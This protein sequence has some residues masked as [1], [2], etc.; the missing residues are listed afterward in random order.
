MNSRPV[1]TSNV[2]E[3]LARLT[4]TSEEAPEEG[5]QRLPDET[6]LH[7]LTSLTVPETL[8]ARLVCRRWDRLMEDRSLWHFFL[9]RDF[10]PSET[11]NPKELYQENYRTNPNLTRGIYSTRTVPISKNTVCRLA[12][13]KDEK[14]IIPNFDGDIKIWDLQNGTLFNTLQSFHE[15][16]VTSLIVTK[17]GKVIAGFLKG[18]IQIWDL[19]TGEREGSFL[20][21][22]PHAGSLPV[23]AR[24]LFSVDEKTLI[25][26]DAH[27]NVT[28][29]DLSTGKMAQT[30]TLDPCSI[31]YSLIMTKEGNFISGEQNGIIRVWDREGSCIKTLDCKSKG[32]VS[33][34]VLTEEG[35]LISICEMDF[36]LKM[37]NLENGECE[38]T[39]EGDRTSSCSLFLSKRETLLISG[40]EQT[41]KFWDLKSGA[42]VHSLKANLH[43]GRVFFTEDENL[44]LC[45]PYC[46]TAQ[47]LNFRA[48]N[49]EI[50]EE[51]AV[52]FEGDAKGHE[53]AMERFSKM[54]K[55]ERGQ[56]Y[57]ELYKILKLREEGFS[58]SPAHAFHDLEGFSSTPAEKAQAIRN[59]LNR[60]LS[61]KT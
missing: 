48:S 15:G 47:V 2:T 60:T 41:V 38:L 37:W 57:I 45:S 20:S 21:R 32:M 26:V 52:L 17:E 49:N 14:L 53:L 54:P 11:E 55:D 12:R 27:S 35:K 50:F 39:M 29:W 24:H 9:G 6:M 34:L 44:I 23:A 51:L 18:R 42:C 46:G 59:Y 8:A 1:T 3:A 36:F 61:N 16:V 58:G 5:M 43:S 56:I 13:V 31:F 40:S 4:L 25:S 22:P 28:I 19:Q 10:Q 33:A 30:F 7:I